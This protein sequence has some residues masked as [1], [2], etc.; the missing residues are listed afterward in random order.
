MKRLLLIDD[1]FSPNPGSTAESELLGRF[2]DQLK[3]E[4]NIGLSNPNDWRRAKDGEIGMSVWNSASLEFEYAYDNTSA[5]P[6][7]FFSVQLAWEYFDAF[8]E[9]DRLWSEIDAIIIDIAMPLG[10]R[11][12][13]IYGNNGP[14]TSQNVGSYL[15]NHLADLVYNRRFTHNKQVLLPVVVLTNLD[16][17]ASDGT[18]LPVSERDKPDPTPSRGLQVWNIK[19]R[20]VRKEENSKWFMDKLQTIVTSR[21]R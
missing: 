9:D 6:N 11:L 19:K 13:K 21:K 7:M 4:Y 5:C 12:E 17:R 3:P 10:T 20:Y 1:D 8:V 18:L 2:V 14:V 16:P 15:K